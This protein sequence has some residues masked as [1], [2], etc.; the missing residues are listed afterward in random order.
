M[1]FT[2]ATTVIYF[3]LPRLL[4]LARLLKRAFFYKNLSKTGSLRILNMRLVKYL[5]SFD[6]EKGEKITEL[7][8][9]YPHVEFILFQSPKDVDS[10]IKRNLQ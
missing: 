2:K 4:C 1:R 8:S 6:K 3:R 7:H 5:W 10:F 9:K